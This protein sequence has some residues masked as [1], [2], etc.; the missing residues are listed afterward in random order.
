MSK[1]DEILFKR[2]C[3]E[4][5]NNIKDSKP[6]VKSE[7]I[8]ELRRV[9]REYSINVY[10]SEPYSDESFGDQGIRSYALVET[11]IH[12]DFDSLL[13]SAFISEQLGKYSFENYDEPN[14]S[15]SHLLD[16]LFLLNSWLGVKVK[17]RYREETID[18]EVN[19]RLKAREDGRNG[20]K[21]R[22]KKFSPVKVELI[23][24]LF[25]KVPSQGW[26]SIGEAISIIEV[27]LFNFI[28]IEMAKGQSHANHHEADNLILLWDN[29]SETIHRWVKE[30]EIVKSVFDSIVLT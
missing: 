27:E 23:R 24:L 25:E 30:D 8:C 16:A 13:R 10:S 14:E 22:A 26:G 2:L 6:F 3:D 21:E 11:K 17:E 28:E 1:C 18:I 15:V 9:A 5:D 20:G 4:F 12:G 7:M 19:R 29:L